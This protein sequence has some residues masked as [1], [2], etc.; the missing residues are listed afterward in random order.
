MIALLLSI[1]LVGLFPVSAQP[2]LSDWRHIWIPMTNGA[3]HGVNDEYYFKLDG[4]GLNAMHITDD[5]IN[6]YDGA[7]YHGGDSGTFWVSDTG[8]RGFNDDIIILASVLGT[9]GPTFNL[10]VNSSGYTWP[11]TYNAAVPA[12]NTLV[13][14]VGQNGTSGIN[15]SFNTGNYLADEDDVDIAQIWRPS[16]VQNYPIYY[17]QNMN[18]PSQEF[19]L[20]FI[21]LKGGNI[22]TNSSSVSYSANLIDRGSA[23]VDYTVEG[24]GDAKLAFNTYGWCNW[25]NQQK[26]V[27]WTNS[28]TASPQSGWDINF[29]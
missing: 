1:G 29:A 8:G 24:L 4:G 5:P 7:V 15:G 6:D 27:S 16:T 21:D 25:S 3:R 23:R 19:N 13:Y 17:G 12:E 2:E 10:K 14:N 20:I 18:D 11:L 9:P 26:G 22:G 28:L